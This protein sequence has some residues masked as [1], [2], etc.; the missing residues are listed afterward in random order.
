MRMKVRGHELPRVNVRSSVSCKN[1]KP[2]ACNLSRAAFSHAWS[3]CGNCRVSARAYSC[4]PTHNLSTEFAMDFAVWLKKS[5]NNAPA[6]INRPHK[7]FPNFKDTDAPAAHT[8]GFS[9]R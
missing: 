7:K 1:A 8:A 6:D 9:V 3:R 4:L 2:S 5:R